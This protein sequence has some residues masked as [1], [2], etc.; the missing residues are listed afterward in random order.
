MVEFI[1]ER[2]KEARDISLEDGIAK[3]KAYFIDPPMHFYENY[4]APVNTILITNGY[5]DCIIVD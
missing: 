1:A 3:Y 5:E 4:R 2:I